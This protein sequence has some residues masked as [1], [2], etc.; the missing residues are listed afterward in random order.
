ME[1][2]LNNSL[3][4]QLVVAARSMK[5]ALEIKLSEYGITSSQYAVL[6]LLWKSNG[7]SLS[8]LGKALYFD[9][10]TITGIINRMARAKLVRRTRNRNDRRVIKVY[11]TP[12]GRE[13]Q[14]ILPKL[15]DAVNK[16]AVENFQND[17]KDAILDLA[18]RIHNN[19]KNN[20]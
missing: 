1:N 19:I 17:E 13:L 3:G 16:Q 7:I 14:S 20:S 10:P 18:T 8:D 12:K 5:H 11:L 2:P 4:F 9:N 6:E 15:A